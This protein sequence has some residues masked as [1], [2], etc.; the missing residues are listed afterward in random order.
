[1]GAVAM[2]RIS[3][4]LFVA[5]SAFAGTIFPPEHP[6]ATLRRDHPR[7]IASEDDFTKD[8]V[9]DIVSTQPSVPIENPNSGTRKLVIHLKKKL[10]SARIEVVLR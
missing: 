1:M 2:L 6:L 4:V 7:L 10:R 3:F 5:T 8:A 9:F